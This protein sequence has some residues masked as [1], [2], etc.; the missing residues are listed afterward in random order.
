MPS[1][2][3]TPAAQSIQPGNREDVTIL[4]GIE[5]HSG[6]VLEVAFSADG[7]FLASAGADGTIRLW[8]VP[9][10]RLLTTIEAHTGW[11]Q[12]IAFSPDGRWLASGGNDAVVRVWDAG[13]LVNPRPFAEFTGHSGF[14]FGLSFSPDGRFLA[15]GS[16]DGLMKVWEVVN[17]RE[18]LQ[19]AAG[20]SGPQQQGLSAIY[21][22]AFHTEG[23]QLASLKESGLVRVQDLSGK[24]ICETFT[25]PAK[26]IAYLPG[27]N[28]LAIGNEARLIILL[29]TDRCQEE[30]VLE[31]HEG[32]VN[33][34]ALNPTGELL[35]S[36]GEDMTVRLWLLTKDGREDG[37]ATVLV[38]HGAAVNSV[39]FSPDGLFVASADAEGVIF[40]WGLG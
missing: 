27:L 34:V 32:A 29:E 15:S 12:T 21:D 33:A 19:Q 5:G 30:A 36:A 9:S 25:A 7:R 26:T 35:I 31:G 14:I 20:I 22:V 2:T 16:G 38:G 40:I 6:P 37:E 3:P 24:V 23:T 10:G 17:G 28:V 18:L 13:D 11:V 8:S 1:R 4:S 39:A